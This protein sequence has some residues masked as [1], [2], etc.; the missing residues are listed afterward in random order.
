MSRRL[1]IFFHDNCFDGTASAAVFADFYRARFGRDVEVVLQGVQHKTGDPFEGHALD[2]DDNACVDFR[3]CDDDRMTWWF[4]H[5]VSAFQPQDKRAHFE[6]D[7]SGQ[8]FY[9][10]TAASNTLFQVGVL[11][12]RFGYELPESLAELVRWADII[13]GA[14]FDSARQAVELAEPAMQ[15]MTWLE[16]NQDARLTHRY[17][18]AL[19]RLSFEQILAESWVAE[20]L[21]TLMAKHRDDI[22]LVRAHAV[23]RGA[24]VFTDLIDHVATSPNKFISYYLHPECSYALSLSRV[25]ERVKISLGFNP[26]SD[27]ERSHNIAE[28]CE[29][30]GGGGHPFVGAVSLPPGK[31]DEARSICEQIRKELGG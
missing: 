24:V 10:P 13:D 25:P 23:S 19:S 22:E 17:I 20:P 12:E 18:D 21:A 30:Y 1:K 14:Q 3:Y 9:D 2:G 15:L 11:T 16:H 5:H 26:W 7:R 28:I 6:A 29:R 27:V 8:K 4:D 31:V